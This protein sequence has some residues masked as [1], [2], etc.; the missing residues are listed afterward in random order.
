MKW[1]RGQRVVEATI[2][3]KVVRVGGSPQLKGKQL[4]RFTC[5]FIVLKVEAEKSALVEGVY[6]ACS[7]HSQECS[8]PNA[9][10]L[11]VRVEGEIRGVVRDHKPSSLVDMER[12]WV[13]LWIVD[14]LVTETGM[15]RSYLQVIRTPLAVQRRISEHYY[16]WKHEWCDWS[17]HAG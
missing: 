15:M 13:L 12:T 7:R 17:N 14:I 8:L 2:S 9:W 3:S 10:Q 6:L 1:V 4:V 16:K 11:K 5:G